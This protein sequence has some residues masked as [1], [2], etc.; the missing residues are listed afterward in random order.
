MHPEVHLVKRNIENEDRGY[1]GRAGRAGQTEADRVAS[2][3]R[4]KKVGCF[5]VERRWVETHEASEEVDPEE[6]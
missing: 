3:D 4:G 5:V 1:E 6:W 2:V